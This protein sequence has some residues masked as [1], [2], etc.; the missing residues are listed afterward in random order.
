MNNG[1]VTMLFEDHY[2]V[3]CRSAEPIH[4]FLVNFHYINL[5]TFFTNISMLVLRYEGFDYI[6]RI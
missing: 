4:G 6:I 1:T 2:S 5:G 3:G